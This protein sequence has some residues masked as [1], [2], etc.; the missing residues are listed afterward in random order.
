[1]ETMTKQNLTYERSLPLLT[2][3]EELVSNKVSSVLRAQRSVAEKFAISNENFTSHADRSC[4]VYRSYVIN[5]QLP[6]TLP[7]SMNSDSV[8]E[9]SGWTEERG[10]IEPLAQKITI[11]FECGSKAS[12]C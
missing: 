1:M 6:H 7:S 12:L 4:M 10:T 2:E 8:Q 3:S 5:P 9:G 11:D